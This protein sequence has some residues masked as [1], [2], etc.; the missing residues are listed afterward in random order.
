MIGVCIGL[1]MSITH[2]F[3]LTGVHVHINLL[4]WTALTLAGFIYHFFPETADT[5]LA[6]AHFWLHNLG[7]PLM[8]IGLAF[9]V[10]GFESFLPLVA[11]GGTVT[12]LS[13]LL[14]GINILSKLKSA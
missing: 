4:G 10:N 9:Y 12:T 3:T 13:I 1:F 11:V 2:N 7:L 6:K 14:F 5:G 8:M